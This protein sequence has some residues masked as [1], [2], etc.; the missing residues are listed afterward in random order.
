MAKRSHDRAAVCDGCLGKMRSIPARHKE[1][2]SNINSYVMEKTFIDLVTMSRS[3]AGNRYLLTVE[4]GFSRYVCCYPLPNKEAQTIA[5][6]LAYEHF[7]RYGLTKQV[8]SDQ[9]LEF[10]NQIWAGVCKLLQ[11]NHTLTPPYNPSS[12]IVERAHRTL[13][14]IWRS[15]TDQDFL[16]HW[17]QLAQLSCFAYNSAVHSAIGF[18]PYKVFFGRDPIIPLDLI[19]PLPDEGGNANGV[20]GYFQELQTRYQNM[21]DIMRSNQ[22]KTILRRSHL[23]KPDRATPIVV[24]TKVWYWSPRIYGPATRKLTSSFRGPYIVVRRI[25][26]SLAV[27]RLV[28]N[29][30][31]KELTVSTDTLRIYHG[32]DII[33]QREDVNQNTVED[34]GDEFGEVLRIP[35]A[36]NTAPQPERDIEE[37]A[38]LPPSAETP[39]RD[40]RVERRT[41]PAT[42]RVEPPD[43]FQ[44]P[45]ERVP[46]P[47]EQTGRTD[48]VAP[49]PEPEM[50]DLSDTA[51]YPP[52]LSDTPVNPPPAEASSEDGGEPPDQP[53]QVDLPSDTGSDEWA[54]WDEYP[55]PGRPP[56]DKQPPEN[57]PQFEKKRKLKEKGEYTK[58]KQRGAA[59]RAESGSEVDEDPLGLVQPSDP[60]DA[61]YR[62]DRA[63]VG[64]G[65]ANR[66]G[67]TRWFE[68]TCNQVTTSDQSPPKRQESDKR[69]R[70]WVPPAIVH[71]WDQQFGRSKTDP[72]IVK[73]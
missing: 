61:D 53:D 55:L 65:A 3:V 30:Q 62:P 72:L 27:I 5:R 35:P 64:E 45:P 28:V 63:A 16:A 24:G 25:A 56:G 57:R 14:T 67:R 9:G 6:I 43:E 39:L 52:E 48:P 2:H 1:L 32:G 22:A 69:A 7:P 19:F 50:E 68:P 12:N 59:D 46:E 18:A 29:P 47:D 42:Y 40:D 33:F 71:W 49:G 70:S 34:D 51:R 13:G 8:H 4:D 21:F 60:E 31:A 41:V 20:A 58:K 10:V 15:Q 44:F 36:F 38:P 73:L 26:P 23:Y 17:D 11:I 54:E 37:G 66:R